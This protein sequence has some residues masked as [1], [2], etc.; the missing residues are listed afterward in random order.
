[1]TPAARGSL[2]MAYAKGPALL[3]DCLEHLPQACLEYQPGPEQWSVAT[4][5]LHLAESELH[6]YLR[7][8][9]IIAEPGA[10]LAV[11]DQVRWARTLDDSAQ[12]LTEAVDLFRLLREMMA[13]QL[14]ALPET[15]WNQTAR[16]PERGDLTLERWLEIYNSHLDTHLAQI[17][18][19]YQAFLAAGR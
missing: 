15:A 16:H 6:G 4:I 11:F 3:A 14:R 13:R 5:V 10:D 2:L 1:M 18:R 7:G 17:R 19:T 9:T 12:P 8:R